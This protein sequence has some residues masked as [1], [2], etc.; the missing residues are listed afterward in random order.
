MPVYNSEKF[1]EEAIRSILNQSYSNFEFL[2]YDDN[3]TDNSKEIIQN[4]KLQDSRIKFFLSKKNIGYAKLLNKMIVDAKFNFFARM[5]ADDISEKTRFEKQLNFLLKNP[6]VSVV[7]SFAEI[8]NEKGY[9]V[10]KSKYPINYLEIKNAFRDY[11][12]FVHSAVIL[13]ADFVKQ[14]GGYRACM[15]PAEDYDLWTRL[16]RVSSMHNLPEYLLKYRRHFDSVS[17]ARRNEQ[18]FNA[19]IIKKNYE[20]LLNGGDDIIKNFDFKSA[21]KNK[22]IKN[23]P[24][25][26]IAINNGDYH[27][28]NLKIFFYKKEYILFAYNFILLFF[29]KPFFLIK[30]LLCKIKK[31]LSLFLPLS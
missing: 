31:N 9:F 14:V 29:K 17:F 27:Y 5:D 15:S 28:H 24:F 16:A 12:A 6:K 11:C 7:G 3:S 23:F 21:T 18:F 20:N 25:L 2:I 19:E 8:I 10:T 22:L 30:K 4:F 26:K 1:L 13:R